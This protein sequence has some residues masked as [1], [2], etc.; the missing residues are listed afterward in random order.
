MAEKKVR[1]F[2][3]QVERGL[4]KISHCIIDLIVKNDGEVPIELVE[5][6]TGLKNVSLQIT[7]D[8]LLWMSREG[9][10][11]INGNDESGIVSGDVEELT[12]IL[13]QVKTNLPNNHGKPWSEMDYVILSELKLAETDD[14]IIAKKLDRTEKSVSMQATMLHKAFKLIPIIEKYETV[15]EFVRTPVSPNP[16]D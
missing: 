6:W 11:Q 7:A 15:R 4:R 13:E 12:K 14:A 5:E 9:I 16:A 1:Q 2:H 10:I 3:E 8:I